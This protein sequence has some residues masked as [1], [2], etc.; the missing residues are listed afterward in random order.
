MEMNPYCPHKNPIVKVAHSCLTV[1]DSIDFTVCGILQARILERVA[2]PFSRGS[3]Q[4]RDRTQVSR[5]AGGSFTNQAT[6]ETLYA[7]IV[8]IYHEEIE[9]QKR[10]SSSACKYT[11]CNWILATHSSILPWKISRTE[12]P[13]GLQSMG[14]Q[15]VGHNWAWAYPPSQSFYQ[16]MFWWFSCRLKCF[17]GNSAGKESPCNAGDP[18]LISGCRRSTG[19]GIGYPLQ[20]SWLSLVAQLVKNLPAIRETWVW[21]LK[22]QATHSRILAW[23]VTESD[24]IEQLSFSLFTLWSDV[25]K[26]AMIY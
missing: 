13:G 9:T 20:Y 22:S 2:C 23:R 14:S 6:R 1:Y 25:W 11:S 3:S 4:P 12:K 8:P 17:P 16:P 15:R 21:F 10:L 26:R 18:G 5:I 24:M 7:I 19:E